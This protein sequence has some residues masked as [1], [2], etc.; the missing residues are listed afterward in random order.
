MYRFKAR[1]CLYGNISKLT[2]S[3]CILIYFSGVFVCV[4]VCESSG[5]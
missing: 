1:Y 5:M 3:D 4:S 2:G